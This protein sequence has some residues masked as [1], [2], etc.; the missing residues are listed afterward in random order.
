MERIVWLTGVLGLMALYLLLR[1]AVWQLLPHPD[2]ARWGAEAA[3]RP[4]R[5]AA[6]RGAI[7]DATGNVLAIQTYGC[8]VHVFPPR[9]DEGDRR[10]KVTRLARVLNRPEE[11]ISRLAA[12]PP[13][14]HRRIVAAGAPITV[15][16]A[17]EPLRGSGVQ[18]E[19][20]YWRV[21]PD[22]TLAAHVLGFV[23]L[24]RQGQYGIEGYHD[25]ALRGQ[26]GAWYGVR[27]PMGQQLMATLGG[28]RPPQD[29]A[30]LTLTLDRN[31]Q[32]EAERILWEGVAENKATSGNIIVLDPR[33]GAIL[34]MASFPS[35]F[36]GE[37]W[38]IASDEE[39]RNSSV[40]ALYEPGSV[41]KPMTLAAAL[42]TK[43]ILATDTYDDRGSIVVGE[44]EIK[45][46]DKRAHGIT[47]MTE[48]LAYSRNVGAAH[49]ASLLGPTRFYEM[50]R[51]FGFAE[52]TGVD[53]IGEERGVMRVPGDPY[54]HMSDLG[55]NSYGQGM[56]VTPLQVAAAYGALANN[57]VLMRPYVVAEIQRGDSV[58]RTAPLPVRQV[59]APDVA[60]QMTRLLEEAVKLGMRPALVAGYRIAGKS[61]TAGIPDAQGYD[62]KNV[63]ASFIGYG[64]LPNPRYV[65]LIKF[66]AP[67]EGSWGVQVA[68]P[69]FRRLFQ[70]LMDYAG[71][72]SAG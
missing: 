21:Y 13:L 60:A 43:V 12:L 63:V 19:T 5:I 59:V 10:A 54:W 53:L 33:T 42:E 66:D 70:F 50:F 22:E 65:I 9:F 71:I 61:G 44:Q 68:A 38:Y 46:S 45:N 69:E 11:S 2:Y 27:G 6:V 64:P 4:D 58:T 16:E 1:L 25:D 31:I 41:L 51:R 52:H 49:V 26:D 28:Y 20:G 57:G 62:N 24:E 55:R 29:G 17:L 34:A 37:Y 18:L 40:A 36:P 47:T 35:Y 72:P 39:H 32:Y 56:S 15:C 30:D 67:K 14:T 3:N 48:L 7:R 23:D 8:N